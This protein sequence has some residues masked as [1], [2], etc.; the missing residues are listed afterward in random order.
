MFFL[1]R[2][3]FDHGTLV[4]DSIF[5]LAGEFFDEI[6]NDI[7]H[8]FRQV[9]FIDPVN[10]D[11]LQTIAVNLAFH[12]QTGT[13]HRDTGLV[14]RFHFNFLQK[15]QVIAKFLFNYSMLISSSFF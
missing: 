9:I 1:F 14:G 10:A 15:K 3:F 13:V 6:P 4:N 12:V 8:A 7:S 2:L 5:H 11:A